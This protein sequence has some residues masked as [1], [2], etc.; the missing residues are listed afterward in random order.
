MNT[1]AILTFIAL[2]SALSIF[3]LGEIVRLLKIIAG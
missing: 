1:N 3:L 2:M